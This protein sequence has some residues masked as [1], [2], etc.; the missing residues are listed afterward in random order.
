MVVEPGR[1]PVALEIPDSLA[2]ASRQRGSDVDD[3][4]VVDPEVDELVSGGLRPGEGRGS[5]E[6]ERHGSGSHAEREGGRL[7]L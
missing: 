4:A 2:A 7:D 5:G 1:Q 6:Q 3:Q